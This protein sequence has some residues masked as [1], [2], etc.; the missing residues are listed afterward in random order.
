[1]IKT[2]LV[3]LAIGAVSGY[4]AGFIMKSKG[5][6]IEN[7]ILGILGGLVAGVLFNL[8]GIA[9]FGLIGTI[10]ESIIGACLLIFVAR[11]IL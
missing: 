2:V 9:F 10:I 4:I 6:L 1:M 5:K 3:S 11:K 8:I 7:I